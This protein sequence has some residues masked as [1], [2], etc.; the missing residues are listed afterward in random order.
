MAARQIAIAAALLTL[1]AIVSAGLVALIFDATE[2][3]IAANERE[4]LRA[5]LNEVLPPVRYDNP[6]TEDTLLLTAPQVTGSPSPA[7]VYRARKDGEPV[8]VV[9]NVTAPDGYSGP[10]R[11]LVGIYAD[12]S[13]AGVRVV[14]HRETPGLGDP[15]EAD[16]SDWILGFDGKSL[17]N[18]PAEKWAVKKDGGVFDQLTGATITPRAVVEA[19][20][21]ALTY[22]EGHKDELFATSAPEEQ[23]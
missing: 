6:I 21:R 3:E 20:Q 18:P 22:F 19:V 7:L 14:S 23:R 13:L 1:V 12:G 15:I 9:M 16:K 8:A 17:G 10:I 11:L 4:A 2:D 5:Q